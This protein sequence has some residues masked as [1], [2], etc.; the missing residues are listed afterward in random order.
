MED[1][2]FLDRKGLILKEAGP[3]VA[4]SAS[5]PIVALPEIQQKAKDSMETKVNQQWDRTLHL[6]RIT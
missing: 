5:K 3:P 4:N 6:G 1:L 2:Y